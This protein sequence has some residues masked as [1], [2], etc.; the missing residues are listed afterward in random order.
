M[1]LT[2]AGRVRLSTRFGFWAVSWVEVKADGGVEDMVGIMSAPV[3]HIF[4]IEILLVSVRMSMCNGV[5][6]LNFITE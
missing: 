5:R 2:S 3:K 4:D 6:F 1:A